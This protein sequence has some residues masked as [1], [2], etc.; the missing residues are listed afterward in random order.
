MVF[1]GGGVILVAILFIS[2]RETKTE[3]LEIP[4]KN[5]TL[6]DVF[7]YA[8]TSAESS[9]KPATQNVVVRAETG[10]R[11]TKTSLPDARVTRGGIIAEIENSAQR[12]TLL[13]AE[14]VLESARAN[15]DKT[16]GGLRQEQISLLESGVSGAQHGAVNALLAAYATMDSSIKETADQLFTDWQSGNIFFFKVTTTNSQ[17]K[18]TL[19][20]LRPELSV[21][22]ARQASQAQT[23]STNAD[24]EKELTL[25]EGEVRKARTFADELLAALGDAI[26]TEGVSQGDIASYRT[27]V[28]AVRVSLT[29]TLNALA[30]ARTALETATQNLAQGQSHVQ[31]TDLAGASG[32]LKQAEGA[33]AAA[34]SAYNKTI[35]RAPVSGIISSCGATVGDVITIG[36]DVCRI[37]TTEQE[38]GV[39]Y[40]LPLSSVRYTPMGTYVATVSEEGFIVFI[41]V[42]VG[43][44]TGT[45]VSVTGLLGTERIVL[46]VRGLKDGESATVTE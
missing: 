33:Y 5:V 14:G 6:I 37:T 23:I 12:A 29:S 40:K 46:D 27:Q 31:D 22:L 21:I 38:N 9:E 28:T 10:G 20:Q 13:Q 45:H 7:S 8:G 11:V 16:K 39:D 17:R 4:R 1:V 42:D 32:A 36:S 35:I 2:G 34:F 3:A 43:L 19:E 25:T 18:N 30:G 44:V 15:S 41:P 26:P 24:L